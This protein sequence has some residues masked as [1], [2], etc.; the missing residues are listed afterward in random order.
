M[1]HRL[2]KSC[3]QLTLF[4]ID[5]KW[6]ALSGGVTAKDLLKFVSKH[7]IVTVVRLAAV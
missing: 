2:K 5:S 7:R 1:A 6:L 3:P 4:S